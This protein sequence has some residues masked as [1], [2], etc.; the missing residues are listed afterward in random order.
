MEESVMGSKVKTKEQLLADLNALRERNEELELFAEKH[1]LAR[2]GLQNPEELVRVVIDAIPDMFTFIDRDFHIVLSNWHEGYDYVPEEVRNGNPI[3]YRV[4]YGRDEPCENCHVIKVFESGAPYSYEKLNPKIGHVEVR[5][6]PLHDDSGKT[7][8]AAEIIRN[9]S[10]RKKAETTLLDSERKLKAVVDGSPI[11]QFAIDMEHRVTYWNRALEA[12]TGVAASQVIGTTRH[13]Y[14]IYNQSRATLA[15]LVLDNDIGKIEEFYKDGFQRSNLLEGAYNVTAFFPRF[16]VDGRWLY[17]T[18]APLYG[19]GGEIIGALETLED[20]TERKLAENAQLHAISTAQEANRLKIEFLKQKNA[21]L[22]ALRESESRLKAITDTAQDAILMVDSN[23]SITYWNPAAERIFGFTREEAMGS[24]LHGLISPARYQASQKEAFALFRETG[25]GADVGKTVELLGMRKD[26]SEIHVA[27]SLS[28]VG[29]HGEWHAVGMIRD[30]TDKKKAEEELLQAKASAEEA[31]RLKSEFLANMSHEIRTPMN[32]VMGMTELLMDT[33]LTR[34]QGEYATAIKTSAESLMTVI[35]DILDF[36][37]I[38]A[39]KLEIEQINFF[40]RDSI[41]DILQTLSQRAEEKGLELAYD[42][43]PDVP[44]AVIGDPGRLRQIIVNLVGNAVKFTEKG[45]V[46]VCV[47]LEGEDADETRLHFIVRDT[48]IG[49]H[50]EK[51]ERIFQS[52][53]QAD[54]ST[55]RRYGGTGLGLTIS[56]RLVELM[57]G[58][59]WMESEPGKGSAFHFTVR[60]G[61]Q[62]GAP[63]HLVPEKLANMEGLPVLVVDD[64]ATN[65]RIL[66]E[67]LKNWRMRPATAEDGETAL[68]LLADAQARGKPFRLLLLDVNMPGMDGFQLTERIAELHVHQG[69]PIMMITSSGV[70]G[71]AARCREMGISAYLSKPVKQSSLLDAIMTVLGTIEPEGATAPLITQHTLREPLRPLHIL[72]AEDNAVNRRLALEMLRKRGHEVSV[73]RNGRE[74]VNLMETAPKNPFDLI[75]MDV[76][77]PEMDGLEATALIREREKI[78]GVHIPIIAL[79]AHAMKGDREK[80]LNAGMDGYVSK[81]LRA[82]DI[83]TAVRGL[84]GEETENIRALSS[85]GDEKAEI[86][87][88]NQILASMDGDMDLLR[89]IVGMFMEEYPATLDEIK[90]AIST[91]DANRLDRSAHALKGLVGNFGARP[92]YGLAEKLEMMGKEGK[93]EG[94]REALGNLED[95]M[96]SLKKALADLADGRKRI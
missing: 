23:A 19:A 41:A 57:G 95:E 45:E 33:G 80:C 83:F 89:E 10:E 50:P 82:E 29:I 90:R 73:A 4:F 51:H 7:V 60:L 76:Q 28:A 11:P 37:K 5:A 56:A 16:G 65:R 87:D 61:V 13:N 67:M 31:N 62:K 75:L 46:V 91:G 52:F 25:T 55:T 93:L 96:I 77:M 68:E 48:G 34:E 74:A 47:V 35:N 21:S 92:A 69:H 27:L 9:V 63:V 78:T 32:G 17:L 58:R 14:A 20:I 54:A 84:F 64:N 2:L 18:V 59:I 3:C 40:L 43:P 12:L 66:E 39:R 70:R 42:V 71:D 24:D 85:T 6:Y 30:I 36:S 22:E 72:L 8:L 81:P 79:T 1:Q 44:D 15:D 86:F 38:E 49:I 53:T 94:A 26:R 88:R